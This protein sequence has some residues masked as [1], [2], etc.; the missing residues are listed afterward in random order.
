M[1]DAANILLTSYGYVIN[2][3]PIAAQMKKENNKYEDI[4]RSV[5]VGL[6]F[7]FFAY[8][9]M[10]LLS[11][12][13]YGDDLKPSL[14]DN[15]REEALQSNG[16]SIS[17]QAVRIMFLVIFLCNIPYLFFPGKMSMLNMIME[18]K[19]KCFSVRL[20][21]E[22]AI[23]F[24]KNGLETS[25]VDGYASFAEDNEDSLHLDNESDDYENISPAKLLLNESEDDLKPV[26]VVELCDD[27]VYYTI[28]ISYAAAIVLGALY[29]DD[30]TFIFGMI[31][32][33]SES[34]LNFVFPALIVLVGAKHLIDAGERKN[35][36]RC[37]S[38]ERW[39]TI[40]FMSLGI[41]YFFVSN[42]FNLMKFTR[43]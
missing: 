5:A 36:G 11:V 20:E 30:L 4:M 2:L 14:F 40:I 23:K 37:K 43:L 6:F 17:S 34:M 13:I 16:G 27:K 39:A 24:E 3:F 15:L 22:V 21:K 12:G 35:E 28:S 29:I 38:L 41:T 1:I 9:A 42:Y 18:S 26:D 19:E 31:A 8:C 7:C 32:A 25:R 33:F 10:T